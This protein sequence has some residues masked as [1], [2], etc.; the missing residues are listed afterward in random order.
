MAGKLVHVEVKAKDADRA[1]GFWS[2]VF[3][4]QF[5][6]SV[7]PDMDY[8]MTQLSD[9]QGAAVYPADDAGSGLVVYFDT[10]D[11]DATIAK[12][13]ENGGEADDKQPIPGVGW[14]STAKDPDG[15]QFSLFQNDESAS[16]G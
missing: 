12:V 2:G 9:D 14:F 3:G 11:I 15:N 16:P 5:G 6:D 4:W 1:V 7:M 8:R 10:D 13:R